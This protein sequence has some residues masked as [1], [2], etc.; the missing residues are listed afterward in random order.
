MKTKALLTLLLV[1]IVLKSSFAQLTGI[2]SVPGD[3]ASLESAIAALNSSG[4]GTGGVTFNV[5]A[6]YSETFAS[7]SAGIISVS[8]TGANPIVFQK[9]GIGANPVITG[10]HPGVGSFDGIIVFKGSDYITFEGISLLENGLNYFD[11]ERMEWGFALLKASGSAPFN[12]CQHITIKNCN[13]QLYQSEHR[14]TGIYSGNHTNLSDAGLPIIVQEDAN[15]YCKFYGNVISNVYKGISLNGYA[16]TAP[17]ILLDKGNEIG[18]EGGN[19]ITDFGGSN[20]EISVIEAVDQDQIMIANNTITGSGSNQMLM[21]INVKNGQNTFSQIYNNSITLYGYTHVY[22]I[23]V[24]LPSGYS[25]GTVNIHDNTISNCDHYPGVPGFFAAILLTGGNKANI[26]GNTISHNTHN[27]NATWM[28]NSFDGIKC[29]SGIDSLEV[30]S[31]EISYN[32]ITGG[33]TMASISYACANAAVHNNAIHHNSITNPAGSNFVYGFLYG[34]VQGDAAGTVNCYANDIHDLSADNSHAGS[35]GRIAA[36]FDNGSSSGIKKMYNNTISNI[37]TNENAAVATA[38]YGIYLNYNYK[39]NVYGNSISNIVNRADNGTSYGLYVKNSYICHIFN[40]TVSGIYAPNA[41]GEQPVTGMYFDNDYGYKIYAHFNTVYLDGSSSTTGNFGSSAIFSRTNM[42]LEM[43]NNI[44]DNRCV[45]SGTGKTVAYRRSDNVLAQYLSWSGHNDFYAGMPGPNNLIYTDGSNSFPD[46]A[47]YKAYMLSTDVNSIREAQSF[48]ES[49]AFLN[50]AA[51]P[52]NLR[53]SS[54]EE[55]FCESGGVAVNYP[56]VIIDDFDGQPRYPNLGYPDNSAFPANAPDVGAFEFAGKTPDQ[57]PP[58]IIYTELPNT[59]NT[60]PQILN[61]SI[62]DASG[63]PVTG[64]GLPVINWRVNGGAMNSNAGVYQSGNE[65]M[66]TFG[67]TFMPAD[68]IEYYIT[69]QDNALPA[70]NVTSEPSYD[71]DGFTP[72]PPA[73]S[74]PPS[75]LCF[76]TILGVL[77]GDYTIGTGGDFATLSGAGGFFEAVGS[78][79]LT[80][81]VSATI[82]SDLTGEGNHP[83]YGW[84]EEGTGNYKI[85]IQ[86][87]NNVRKTISGS[88]PYGGMIRLYEVQRVFIDGGIA[89]SLLFR[90]SGDSKSSAGPAFYFGNGCGEAELKNCIIEGDIT[91]DYSGLLTIE[92]ESAIQIT[93]AGNEIRDSKGGHIGSPL[94]GIY[95]SVANADSVVI[96]DNNIYNWTSKG[97][98]ISSL[99]GNSRIANNSFFYDQ[100]LASGIQ[101]TAIYVTGRYS[102]PAINGNYIGGQSPLCGG[103]AFRH[104]GSSS[105][106]GIFMNLGSGGGFGPQQPFF[107]IPV[108]TTVDNNMI[109]NISVETDAG[110]ASDCFSGIRLAD[111]QA[112]IGSL[113]GNQIGS[114]TDAGPITI[115][116]AGQSYGIFTSTSSGQ[117]KIENNSVG[118]LTLTAPAGTPQFTGIYTN[119]AFVSKNRISRIGVLY[120]VLT[121]VLTGIHDASSTMTGSFFSNNSISLDGGT[122]LNPTVY[123]I[124]ATGS[125]YSS[126][127]YNSVSIIGAATSAAST[128]AFYNGSGNSF[129]VKDNIFSNSRLPGGAGK[130]YSVYSTNEPSSWDSDYND[131]YSV[132]E[133]LA[134]WNGSDISSLANWQAATFGDMHSVSTNPS[135]VSATDLH[136]FAGSLDNTGIYIQGIDTDL[137]GNATTDPPDIGCYQFSAPLTKTL[138]LSLLLEGLYAGAG[139][140]NPAMDGNTSL[141]QW[142][143]GI[144]DKIQVQLHEATSPY[145]M[146]GSPKTVDLLTDGTVQVTMP[147]TLSGDYYIAVLHRN[148]LET[149]SASPVSFAGSSI[150]YDFS[151]AA[152]AAFGNNLKQDGTLYLLYSGDVNQDGNID[153]FDIDLIDLKTSAFGAGYLPEDINGDGITDALDLIITDNNGSLF[154]SVIRP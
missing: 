115:N 114:L 2:K 150:S 116:G 35:S 22:P 39:I 60:G 89:K 13:I 140:M 77:C 56:T 52:Y 149:W 79:V 102:H 95:V 64:T 93:V 148:S 57:V 40:N 138:N 14:T 48:S 67:T 65:Y 38:A 105:F 131:L 113:L 84:L 143:A 91:N 109:Q 62:S 1:A 103:S 25:Y 90:S 86:S 16:D 61:A 128:Y 58:V 70:A 42:V 76:Y 78:S 59:S 3:Y 31:N 34:I 47:G 121:P 11:D 30:Y 98:F 152:S 69:A 97:I 85:T 53:L 100:P 32:T 44:L 117:S 94:N 107:G 8:G 5:A 73:C 129:S 133:P 54:V 10:A 141:P 26:Y 119:A 17:Y 36:I 72:N 146:V 23:S 19:L 71:A 112:N 24:S 28:A 15:S 99:N 87:N 55:T 45:P 106:T 7:P 75:T 145:N 82:V 83:L 153:G 130:H 147:G 135:F 144:A 9:Y 96:R 142:G 20:Y 63:V 122:A 126:Y 49:P 110:Y 50:V 21:G 81:D 123:G 51:L 125:T 37:I 43:Q 6:G 68:I 108:Y 41:H 12:G 136:T 92:T 80:C 29:N 101:Q 134:H 118:N 46:I 66:F 154:I 132:S 33:G 27:A 124:Q 18:V 127:Y 88:Y 151:G 74:T 104:V 111:G 4:V 137:A 139:T 120:P